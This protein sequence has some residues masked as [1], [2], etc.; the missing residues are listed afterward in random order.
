ML[1]GTEPPTDAPVPPATA[2]RTT[3]DGPL[4]SVRDLSVRFDGREVVSGV[5]FDLSE[6]Q[7]LGIVGESG[8]GKSTV[9]RAVLRLIPAASGRVLFEGRDL[10]ALGSR[11]MR[12]ARRSIQMVFQDPG[13]SLNPRM[14]VEEIVA[15]PLRVF[16]LAA[17]GPTLRRRV[18]SLLQRCGLP[19]DAADRY[20]HQ[21][22]GGQKQRIAIARAIALEPRLLVC[23]EPT[24]ALDVSVQASIL[25]LLTHLQRDMGI[26][27]LFISHDLAVVR[28]MC[29]RIAVMRRGMIIEHGTREEVIERPAHA[30]TRA[31]IAAI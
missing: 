3:N 8:S 4:L 9:A 23:D 11:A 27:Y 22:S 6:G 5:S 17:D 2:L 7:S 15:E 30:Y 18:Q 10:L 1:V 25:N 29:H 31:L 28:H 21:F 14:R 20:P 24:S 13:G 16:R 12:E 26:A 19:P